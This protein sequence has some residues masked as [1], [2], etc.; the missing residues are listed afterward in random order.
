MDNNEHTVNYD[1]STAQISKKKKKKK[2]FFKNPL[3]IILAVIIVLYFVGNA[4][5]G[6]DEENEFHETKDN[7]EFNEIAQESTSNTP[8]EESVNVFLINNNCNLVRMD[9]D[10]TDDDGPVIS[11]IISSINSE[12]EVTKTLNGIRDIASEQKVILPV[13]VYVMEK[14]M[15]DGESILV[16]RI[17]PELGIYYTYI[18]EE[19]NSEYFYWIISQFNDDGSHQVLTELL[20]GQ[21]ENSDSYKHVYTTKNIITNDKILASVNDL[22]ASYGL[23]ETLEIYDVFME[24]HFTEVNQDGREVA[25]IAYGY[26]DYSENWIYLLDIR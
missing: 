4:L 22:I 23:D 13:I 5:S 21:L 20:L 2:P 26:I 15:E 12:E 14:G 17:T 24:M 11:I 16:A 18:G 6:D 3:F 10:A 25:K 1:N 7:T 8:F 9:S 19:Y